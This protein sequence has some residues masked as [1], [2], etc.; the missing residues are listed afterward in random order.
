M[1]FPNKR[2]YHNLAT[3]K[4]PADVAEKVNKPNSQL[5]VNEATGMK[6]ST[7][8]K[9]K[10]AIPEDTCGQLKAMDRLTGKDIQ[11]WRQDNA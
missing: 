9:N 2:M 11:V 7:F 5:I 8:H 1:I 4:A 10:D 3:V 6:F